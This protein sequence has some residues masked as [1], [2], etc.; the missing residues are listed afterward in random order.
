MGLLEKAQQKRQMQQKLK[1]PIKIVDS[2]II[3]KTEKKTEQK[4]LLEKA[5]QKR[6]ETTTEKKVQTPEKKK[7]YTGVKVKGKKEVIE[8]KKGFGWKGLGKRRIVFEQE[9]N[10]YVYE[11]SEPALSEDEKETKEERF[12][13]KSSSCIQYDRHNL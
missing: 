6:K 4:G 2:T 7:A 9:I 1:D 11:L 12:N 13:C 3:E 8:E 10:E 5:Q